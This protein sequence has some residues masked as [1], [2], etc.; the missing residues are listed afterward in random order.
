MAK[1]R[2]MFNITGDWSTTVLA[3]RVWYN[4]VFER[5]YR[6]MAT[7]VREEEK[8]SEKAAEEERG[9]RGGQD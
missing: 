5:G 7:S 6:F 9:G 4:T 1:D 2:R 8:T 3:P